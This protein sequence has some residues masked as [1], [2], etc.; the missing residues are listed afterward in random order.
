MDAGPINVLGSIC[1]AFNDVESGWFYKSKKDKIWSPW[2]RRWVT[3]DMKAKVISYYD[4]Q[5]KAESKSDPSGTMR[6]LAD[7][8]IE[9]VDDSNGK[10]NILEI[11]G[12]SEGKGDEIL[13]LSAESADIRDHWRRAIEECTRGVL[14]KQPD[15]LPNEFFNSHPLSIFYRDSNGKYSPAHFIDS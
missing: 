4:D 13:I 1:S 9:L 10:Q 6:L 2:R 3:L 15:L 5:G 7:T 11:S 12:V 8:T 14:V